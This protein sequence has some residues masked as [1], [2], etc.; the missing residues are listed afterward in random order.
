M[1]STMIILYQV[2]DKYVDVI[3]R[4]SNLKFEI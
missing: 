4:I 3:E 2:L 1:A